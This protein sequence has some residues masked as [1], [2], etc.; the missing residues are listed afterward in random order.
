MQDIQRGE[1]RSLEALGCAERMTVTLAAAGPGLT[2]D[3]SCFG[4]D[5]QGQLSDD[6]YMVFYN[7][8]SAPGDVVRM[9][10]HAGHSRFALDLAGLPASIAKLVFTATIDGDG[11]M[12][13]L[14][15]GSLVLG[16]GCFGFRGAD[17]TAEKALVIGEIYRHAGAWRFGAVGQGFAGGLAALLAHFGGNEQRDIPAPAQG[18]ASAT[19]ASPAAPSKVTLSKAGEKKMVVLDKSSAAPRLLV[20]KASWVDN[21]DARSDNDDLD[22]RAGLLLPDGTMKLIC[23]PHH[24]G[25]VER[26]PYV[27]HMGDVRQASRKEPATETI[28]V[29]PAIARHCGGRVALVFSVYSALGNG[30]VSV[31]SL[32]PRMRMEYG[33]QVVECA[34]DFVAAGKTDASVYTYVLG[35]A[36]I[37]EDEVLL[38]PSGRTSEPCSEHTPWLRWA[39]KDGLT[40]TMDGPPSFKDLEDEDEE[41]EDSPYRYS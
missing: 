27:Q 8:R 22:L 15:Q 36:I 25:A 38:A 11:T 6:R 7:Q 31:A 28:H 2:V 32:Q 33:S 16:S 3:L 4:L 5:A 30:A 1:K 37:G 17:F 29:N 12:A 20:I 18:L 23:A 34:F 41:L 26:S 39:G 40:I 24:A 19:A 10:E 35:T 14:A 21:G 9:S 13:Q